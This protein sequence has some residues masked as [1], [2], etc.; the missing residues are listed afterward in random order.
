MALNICGR[1]S[2][3]VVRPLIH[4]NQRI[5][6]CIWDITAE[7]MMHDESIDDVLSMIWTV[8]EIH[9]TLSVDVVTNWHITYGRQCLT[10]L[11]ELI[12]VCLTHL[13]MDI[14]LTRSLDSFIKAEKRF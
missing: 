7:D 13:S 1:C 8:C 12:P 5:L 4:L 6:P 11:E 14:Q 10:R 3:K 9:I 2:H